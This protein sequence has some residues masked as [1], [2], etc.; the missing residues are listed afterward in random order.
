[1]ETAFTENTARL[2]DVNA[3]RLHQRHLAERNNTQYANLVHEIRKDYHQDTVTTHAK[4]SDNAYELSRFRYNAT[5]YAMIRN[6]FLALII[7]TLLL[8]MD[9]ITP[10]VAYIIGAVIA[11]IL[12]IYWWFSMSYQEKQRSGVDFNEYIAGGRAMDSPGNG[13]SCQPS[14]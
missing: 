14:E 3:D 12:S 6:G 9:T 11:V 8:R 5:F 2:V 4:M 10:F 1:M 13:D 7:L